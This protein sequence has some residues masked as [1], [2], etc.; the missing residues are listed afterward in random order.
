[1]KQN[2]FITGASGCVGH[3]ILDLLL[4]N[5]DYELYLLVRKPQ[6]LKFNYQDNP[7]A[8]IIRDDFE[9]IKKHAAL[10]QQMDC[11]IHAA[12]Q[13]GGHEINLDHT[14]EL[15]ELLDPQKCRKVLYF[16]TASIL[17]GNNRPIPEAETL[18]TN[19]IRS[20]YQLYKELPKFKIYPN[21]TTLFLTWVFG[22]DKNHPFSHAS[23]GLA[24]IKK[25][26]WLIRFF[27]VD[28]AFHYIHAKDIAAIT[29]HLLENP[30]QENEFVLGNAPISASQ[31]I[32]E[33]S[34]YFNLKIYFQIPLSSSVIKTLAFLSGR[35]L[36]SWDLF[37]F[38]KKYFTHKTV[39]ASSLGLTSKLDSVSGILDD[40]FKNPA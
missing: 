20:K 28:A 13:W 34:R 26:L 24:G 23:S 30:A 38:E 3:Y 11:V 15:L 21:I 7:R 40:L 22:G 6:K 14:R 32:K 37:C 12:A 18:G 35:K 10:L 29:V 16:S 25:W 19:Y 2:I 5:P 39:N 36:H 1:M 31:L 27:T 8:H 17:D 33:V 9:N 4:T